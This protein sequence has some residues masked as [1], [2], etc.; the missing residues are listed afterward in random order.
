MLRSTCPKPRDK[1]QDHDRQ[2]TNPQT[3]RQPDQLH[4]TPLANTMANR[5]RTTLRPMPRMDGAALGRA[6]SEEP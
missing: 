1:R 4:K 3:P 2:G 6:M 5:R